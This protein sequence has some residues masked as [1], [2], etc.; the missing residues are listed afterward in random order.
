M[1]VRLPIKL[2]GGDEVFWHVV[3]I[4][5]DDEVALL[6]GRDMLGTPKKM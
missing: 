4:L 6:L 2:E 3:Y 1:G 5:V